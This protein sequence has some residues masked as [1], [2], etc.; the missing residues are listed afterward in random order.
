MEEYEGFLFAS[1]FFNHLNYSFNFR[2]L[3]N[4]QI[5]TQS[6]KYRIWYMFRI[7]Q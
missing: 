7:A 2:M 3:G 1:I 5:K 4:A 6:I